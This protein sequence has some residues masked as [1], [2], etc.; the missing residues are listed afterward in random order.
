MLPISNERVE[1]IDER[2][3]VLKA[4]LKELTRQRQ[5]FGAKPQQISAIVES[6]QT[7]RIALLL[8]HEII[9]KALKKRAE[10]DESDYTRF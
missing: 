1:Y 5:L 3:R 8:E 4:M 10:D 6:V 9:S 7:E 2:L